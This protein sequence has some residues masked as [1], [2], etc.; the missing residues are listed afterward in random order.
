MSFYCFEQLDGGMFHVILLDRSVLLFCNQ[1]R[2]RG[3]RILVRGNVLWRND[4][5]INRALFG[6]SS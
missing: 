6:H 1:G 3:G 5:T 4:L 2:S